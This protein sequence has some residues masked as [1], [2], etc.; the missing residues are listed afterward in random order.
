MY[1]MYVSLLKLLSYCVHMRLLKAVSNQAPS[2]PVRNRFIPN[3]I[4]TAFVDW[5]LGHITI[6]DVFKLLITHL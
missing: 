1:Y 6:L 3:H 4:H 2:K 5:L